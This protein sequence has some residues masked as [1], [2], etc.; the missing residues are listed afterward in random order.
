MDNDLNTH[1]QKFTHFQIELTKLLALFIYLLL[2]S[3]VFANNIAT[4]DN[5]NPLIVDAEE[6]TQQNAHLLQKSIIRMSVMSLIQTKLQMPDC[7]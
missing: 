7:D 4:K 1:S 2:S 3:S 6:M 5:F